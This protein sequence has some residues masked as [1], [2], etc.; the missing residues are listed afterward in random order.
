M[1][2]RMAVLAAPPLAPDGLADMEKIWGNGMEVRLLSVLADKTPEAIV[3]YA[4]D[5]GDRILMLGLE[6]GTSAMISIDKLIP[7]VEEMLAGLRGQADFALFACAGDFP[8]M[9]SPLPMIQP[10]IVFRNMMK[11]ILQPPMRLGVITP[12][13]KQIPHVFA[14]WLPYLAEAGLS[15]ENLV[16]DWSPASQE[17]VTRCAQRLAAKK[18]DLV[19]VECLGYKEELREVIFREVKKPVILVRTVIAHLVKEMTGVR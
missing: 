7:R 12:G 1:K 14:S 8:R 6:D 4:V 10:N 15:E 11:A 16:V 3:P 9:T 5:G 13:E 19:A 17:S 2:K 18:V